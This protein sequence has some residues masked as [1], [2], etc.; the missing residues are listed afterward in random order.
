[1][2]RAFNVRKQ[3]KT[4]SFEEEAEILAKLY[5]R[6]AWKIFSFTLVK[7]RFS[8]MNFVEGSIKKTCRV[9]G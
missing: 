9:A 1:M 7:L 6:D 4:K 2:L 5:K 8:K 3:S